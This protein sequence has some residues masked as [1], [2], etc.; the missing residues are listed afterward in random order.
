MSFI[1]TFMA[2]FVNYDGIM[3]LRTAPPS[4]SL[5]VVFRHLRDAIA[6]WG[7]LGLLTSVLVLLVWRRVGEVGRRLERMMA[8]FAAGKTLRRAPRVVAPCVSAEAEG[9]AMAAG[10]GA[11]RRK[12]SCLWPRSFAW[13]VR[14]AAHEAAGFGLQMEA[15]LAHPE[16]VA[17]LQ[18]T[19]QAV[20]LLSPICGMLGIDRALLP[21]GA[22]PALPPKPV[23]KSARPRAKPERIK[24]P[25]GVLAAARRL[26]FAN[27]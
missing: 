22:A 23:A 7:G 8:R 14:A 6:R 11:V 15:V 26:R 3:D 13:L 19:P 24:L 2:C 5:P 21:R 18:A 20:R 9:L 17:F 10:E 16:M 25:R 4:L 12:A 27:A 1:L